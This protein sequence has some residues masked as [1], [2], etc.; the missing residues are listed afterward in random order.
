M[1]FRFELIWLKF[2]GFLDVV[3]EAWGTQI[4]GADACRAMDI[5]LRTVA[6]ALK[7]WSAKHVGSIRLQL[8]AARVVLYELDVARETRL[9]SQGELELRRDL[10]LNVL[11]LASLART[12]AR[13]RARIRYLRE[14]DANTRFFHLQACH[15][16]RKN[17]L[18]SIQ[19]E[20]QTFSEEEAQGGHSVHLLQ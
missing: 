16:R 10:K 20:G 11:G 9:L 2:D 1:R 19:H 7:S 4:H 12:V 14:G 5:K 3:R 6:K 13:Q 18:A 15:R 8:A 17:Y